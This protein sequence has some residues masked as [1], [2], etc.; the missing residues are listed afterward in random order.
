MKKNLLQAL[1]FTVV[2]GL[3]STNSAN[4]SN[5]SIKII[6]NQKPIL[7]GRIYDEIHIDPDKPF[8][9]GDPIR[10]VHPI[11]PEK[12]ILPIEP[13]EPIIP[14]HPDKLIVPIPPTSTS[15]TYDVGT[16]KGALSVNNSGA[17]V[18][19]IDISAPN[20]GSLTPSIGVSYNSQS[21][22]GLAGFGF[23]ITG[24]SCITRG[25]KD[26]YHDKQ[27]A[28][29]SYGIGDALFLNGQR[30]IL[31]TGTYGYN[32]STY[33]PEGDPYTIVTLHNDINTSACWFSV[34][35]ADGKTYQLGN[36]SDSR[37]SFVNRKSVTCIAAWYI[38]QTTDVHSNLVKYH[39][40]TTNYN[41]RPVSI[42]YG[43]NTAKSRGITNLILFTYSSLTG[44]YARPFAIGDKQ[45]KMDVYLSK[46]TTQTNGSVFRTYTFTYDS[47]SDKTK[48][49]Y[50]RLTQVGLANGAGRK[51]PPIQINWE[52]LPSLDIYNTNL[53]VQTSSPSSM[54][55]E[56]AKTFIAVDV[57]NDGISDIIR[58]SPGAYV[59]RYNGGEDR[60]WKTFLF[61]S[62][63]K[64]DANGNVTYQTPKQFD[65]DSSFS[66]DDLNNVIGGIQAMD[67]DGDGY[68]DLIIPYYCGYKS[69]YVERY[70]IVWGKSI[71]NGGGFSEIT[72]GLANCDH[73][74]LFTTYDS[75]GDGRDDL[76]YLEDRAK[77]G[78]YNGAILRYKRDS[79][80]FTKFQFKIE[81]DPKKLFVGD[82]NH[83]GLTD[84]IVFYDGGYKIYYNN[85][86]ELS[87][88]KYTEYNSKMGTNLGDKHR[89]VQ[90]DFD[91]DGMIDFAFSQ[92]DWKYG[93]A[94]N[95]GDG[96]FTVNNEAVA[97]SETDQKTVKD[98]NRF[99][100]VA[101]DFDHDGRCDFVITKANYVFHGGFR[102][103]YYYDWTKTLFV[104]STG[105]GFE[106]HKEYI[107][108]QEKDAEPNNIFL[109]D[110]TGDGDVQYASFGKNLL[111]DNDKSDDKIHTYR[112]GYNLV[113]KGKISSIT[114]GFG[115]RTFIHYK[116]ATEPSVYTQTD[117]HSSAYPVNSYTIPVP[118]VSEVIKANDGAGSQFIQYKYGDLKLHVA[119]KGIV[120]FS[121]MTTVNLTLGT[122]E[123]TTV[124]KWDTDK[125][126]PLQTTTTSTV[127]GNSSKIISYT[128]IA[129]N[130]SGQNYYAYTSRKSLT[131]LDGNKVTTVSNYDV[132]KG[133]L[134]DETVKNDGDNMYKK[135][136]YSGYQ[137]KAGV[138][139]PTTL[140]MTQ[141]HRDDA[142]PYTSVTT[143][144]YDD[145]GNVLSS[146]V[147]SGTNMALK[148]T[149]T[150]D[151]YG[152]V[153]SSVI[154]GSGVKTITKYNDY[155]PSGRF[156]I[157]SY[158]NP[159]SAVNTFTYD[160]W[161]NVL[162]ENDAT[163][164]SNILTTKY[165]YDGWGR[166][167]TALLADGTQTTYNTGWGTTSSKK[168]YSKESTTGK[169]SVTV[170]YDKGGHE[171]LQE[172][173]GAK[174]V[175]VS[176]AT[177]YSNGQ[178]SRVENKTG[179]LTITQ[180]L[181]YDKRGR[182]VTDV[183]SSGKSASY[184]YG[185]R[186]VTTTI[187]GRSYTK[188]TD[189]WGNVVK[190]TDPVSE[191]E[192][193]YSSIG[194]PSSVKTQGS[195]V[196]MSYDAA[197]NQLSL[198][199]PDAGTS[200]YTYAA[201]GTLLTQTD[202]R[203]IKT[204]NNYDDLGRLA[205]TQI[206]QKT[207]VYTYGTTGNEKLRLVKLASD[208][209]SVEY[210]HDKFGRVVTEKRNVDRYGAYSFSYA[211][212]SNNQ[213]SKTTYPG[214]LEESY[215][216][217]NFGFKS[218][219]A[220]GDKVIY[221]VESTD[222]LVN[223]TSFMGKLTTTLTRDAR[224]YESNRRIARGSSILEN[225]DESYDGTTD[226]LLSR[227]RNNG[228][229]ET[230]GYDNLD[231]LVSVKSGT[232]E[233]MKIN[234]AS[235]GNIL[236][237]TGIG[238]F[239]YDKNIRPHAVTE[240]ENA[241]GKIPGD[242]LNTS[243]NDFGK[244]QLIEDAGKI[245]RMDFAYGP[246]QER[247]YS[248][249]SHNGT[250]VRTTV[251]AGEYE[252]ITENGNTREFYYLD[253]NTIAIKENGSIKTYLVFTDNLGSILSVMDENGA[254]VFDASYDAWGKQTVTLNTIGLHRGYTGHEMLSEFDIINMNG[255]LYDPVLG[256][257]FS[258]DNYV[259]MPDNSQNFNRYSY[260]LNNPLKY[261]DP[262]GDFWNLIIGA[263]IGGVFNWASH[264]FQ[265]NAKGLGHLVTGAV[266][267]AVGAGL[268]SGVNV[269]MAGGNFWTGAAGLA[270]GISS[271]GFLAGAASGASAGFAS[272]FINN[273]G[274]SWLDG[275]SFGKG[276][277][278]GLGSGGLGTLEGGIAGGLI[279]GLD[280]LDKG[281]NFWTGKTSL[282]LSK[283]YAASGNFG[284]GE[285]TVTGKY[286]G[287]YEGQN[288]FESSK[289]GSYKTGK[290]SGVTIPERGIIVGEGVFTY[291]AKEGM[292][293][294]QHEFGH[295]LE[296]RIIGPQ[297][298]WSVIA[299][300]S[301]C[302][303][304]LS[305]CDAH[306][307]YWTETWANYLSKKHFGVNWLGKFFPRDYP[308]Q[309]ISPTNKFKI[310]LSTHTHSHSPYDPIG[311]PFY[312]K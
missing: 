117:S 122:K 9:P 150:Y 126:I 26:L 256:R 32:S 30:L 85:G 206:G 138:W 34:V 45:G 267:G 272:G 281:T 141:K 189:A 6:A 244:I 310:Y 140:T 110:F 300:E 166:K 139:L 283:G 134:T 277:L 36:T 4:A 1:L 100:M 290:Y 79:L 203:G 160:L 274:N 185:N 37:L 17:A 15:S 202:G 157:K 153:L 171:V 40:T 169:P 52:H 218:Q 238:N 229:Q 107:T 271:T 162:T 115:L 57:N 102:S 81:R 19:S 103:K 124:D 95:N 58:L 91:G 87:S 193:L 246:D 11:D 201:D 179:K 170:W 68:N 237:K 35:C 111:V 159:A 208:N 280:A 27:I 269:A 61:V 25:C 125:W 70:T 253:G 181:T 254:K 282:D 173:F 90:G 62:L 312:Y 303:A 175:P 106:L 309:N 294:M 262:S 227:K 66:M 172:S 49:K 176:K 73:T 131:D 112:S 286:V 161:G 178:I 60:L 97:L 255:R 183:L 21:G 83:D 48:D 93:L 72:A 248:E 247:W 213:L 296:Y 77:D 301:F 86:G 299:P 53:N 56:S 232:V 158:T 82:Y 88:T 204:I 118:L 33:T 219:S 231:R 220:I 43:L 147:N 298:Y 146:T 226:N 50:Y 8:E 154:T 80:D 164:P 132:S 188:A 209:N 156:V 257:F 291:R 233:T 63:S 113:S 12:P 266:A 152:N 190:S 249:L 268:A 51:V 195:T 121:S 259:Q 105:T 155:D 174:G 288:V 307:K 302:S 297:A 165:T 250:D 308:V 240:I 18:Y 46:I 245:L 293:M 16:P 235:N 55:E 29:T 54:I 42:E 38:N 39:Y 71:V 14:N 261:T 207:I 23:N 99:N 168:Y 151:V 104:K 239:S 251:Y 182:V 75:N 137:N 242:A 3:A 59:Q 143:Y 67:F 41:L 129:N 78:Y 92:G 114:D 212:N 119:G 22:N 230:F 108:H 167:Q 136:S 44:S 279:G 20:G 224:G 89:I 243:F 276:L 199:D 133:V 130:I 69:N 123:T 234:Y 210:T 311:L 221:K 215:L 10:P 258:P 265:F 2:A 163:E 109:G 192:Y 305:S 64:K 241:D 187:A 260:C 128:T 285:T 196:T 273:A 144:G 28:G 205:S 135:V 287:T 13:G 214:G 31:K 217:D 270:K 200:T 211:Y 198:T 236:F 7:L 24:L 116:S 177:T 284:I 74:P 223:S 5:D 127:G 191:V 264:G 225:F 76:F 142:A 222:G 289:L 84:I 304:S 184:S 65:L 94:I 101:Y 120:G 149:S 228:P 98:D 197:G 275:H 306:H 194:K 278:A 252:K 96:T 148:T 263:A 180:D 295:I 186:S 47:T 292:A 216:Y 145:K